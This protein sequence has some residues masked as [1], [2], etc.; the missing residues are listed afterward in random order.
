MASREMRLRHEKMEEQGMMILTDSQTPPNNM[1][2]NVS[3]LCPGLVMLY[4]SLSRNK[5]TADDESGDRNNNNKRKCPFT[6]KHTIELNMQKQLFTSTND[7]LSQCILTTH[8][9]NKC[10][11]NIK[12]RTHPK[13]FKIIS[14]GVD[15]DCSPV[16]LITVPVNI[17]H[18]RKIRNTNPW[19]IIHSSKSVTE[20]LGKVAVTQ[21]SVVRDHLKAQNTLVKEILGEEMDVS[22][23][24]NN[25]MM[26]ES[27][28]MYEDM[29]TFVLVLSDPNSDPV[30]WNMLQSFFAKIFKPL[31]VSWIR[32]VDEGVK[33]STV[34]NEFIE[35]ILHPPQPEENHVVENQ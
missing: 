25:D 30:V 22:L 29:N 19:N 18:F 12:K 14:A 15:D 24:F 32:I 34:S 11:V 2:N 26:V 4:N 8:F 5:T 6:G 17:N 27:P 28:N 23:Y 16:V 20:L 9:S 33:K 21:V 10:S 7:R 3:M 31:K 35:T 1:L 13:C